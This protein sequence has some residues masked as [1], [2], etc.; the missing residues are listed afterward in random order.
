MQVS[1]ETTQGLERRMTVTVPAERIDQEVESRLKNLSRTVRLSGFRPGKVPVKV[2]ASRYGTQVR[3]EVINEVT[4]STF[5]EAVSRENLK[6]ASMPSI[7]PKSSGKG[8]D[9]EY[10]AVFEVIGEVELAPL[11]GVEVIK[12]V[13]EITEQDVD[14]MVETLRKQRA[15]WNAVERPAKMDDQV[16]IDFH[17]RISGKDFEGNQGKDVKLVLGSNSFI[18]GFED[19]LVGAKCGETVTAELVFP[20]DYRVKDLAGKPVAFEISVKEVAESVLPDVDEEF[21]R[22]FEV[23]DGSIETF[24]Q[25]IR[26]SMQSELDQAL[27]EKLKQ[28][29]LE[30]LYQQNSLELPKALVDS[31]IDDMQA[32]LQS[33]LAA[34]G[35]EMTDLNL[36]RALFE[37]SARRKVALGMIVGE[38]SRQNNLTVDHDKVRSIVEKLAESYEHPDEVVRW[39]YSDRSRMANIETLALEDTVVDWVMERA[40]AREEPVGFEEIM[41]SRRV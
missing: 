19:K 16:T 20:E 10:V 36:D 13:S 29:V 37:E 8:N 17:G 15:T 6:L 11:E 5:Q 34:Q 31:T 23:G 18:A 14:H 40:S 41:Q 24:R 2:V 25:E 33:T 32:Q 27:R 26:D 9:L 4:Q 3:N 21:M 38:I 28:N 22:S 7:E 1:V 35:A 12:P 30:V 39:Y